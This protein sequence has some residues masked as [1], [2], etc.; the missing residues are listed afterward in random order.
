MNKRIQE[1]AEQAKNFMT[2]QVLYQS[3]VHN[4]TLSIDEGAD[5]FE[6]KFAELIVRDCISISTK[7]DKNPY[8]PDGD[9]AKKIIRELKQHFGVEE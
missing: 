1:L 2:D 5:I 3:R 7:V 8:I 6:E 9:Q 4:R